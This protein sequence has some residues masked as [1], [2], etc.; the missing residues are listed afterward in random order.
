MNKTEAAKLLNI[1][2]RTLERHTSA[3]HVAAQRV[4]MARGF[5]LDYEPAE[6]ERFKAELEAENA[7][8]LES[9]PPSP[10]PSPKGYTGALKATDGQALATIDRRPATVATE[11]N[12]GAAIVAAIVAETVK[13]IEAQRQPGVETKLVLTIDECRQLTGFSRAIIRAAIDAGEL[14]ARQIGRAWR[15]KRGDL[16]K[17]VKEL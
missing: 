10:P 5:A 2:V 15:V 11:G 12:N 3:G 16:D 6:L 14:K 9:P 8:Q 13:A 17:W 1:G 4:K 7:A